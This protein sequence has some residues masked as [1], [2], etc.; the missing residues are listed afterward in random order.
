MESDNSHDATV[1]RAEEGVITHKTSLETQIS[2]FRQPK[3]AHLSFLVAL[4]TLSASVI[5]CAGGPSWNTK[6]YQQWEQKDILQ[7]LNDSP[8]AVRREVEVDWNHSQ[9]GDPND[10]M[11]AARANAGI[12]S[13]GQGEASTVQ[14]RQNTDYPNYPN[15]NGG[16]GVSSG[17]G[18]PPVPVSV[19][20]ETFFT[21]RWNSSRTMQKA[22]LRDG[23]LQGKLTEAMADKY[24]AQPLPDYEIVV[25]GPDMRPF[26]NATEDQLK[27]KG[28]I[29]SRQSKQ[30]VF[31]S[32]ITM[33][34]SPDGKRLIAVLF[35]FPKVAGNNQPLIT[36]KDKGVR[37]ECKIKD[38]SLSADFDLHKMVDEKG[39]DL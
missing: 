33:Q 13:L 38:L 23:V 12:G 5:S 26:V 35:S 39:E 10:S 8:W 28:F 2:R 1:P 37:F 34:R 31:P 4:V 30:K 19:A 27:A 17:A 6:P 7:E 14:Q 32:I 3:Y 21:I 15:Q 9:S 11:A 25:F 24:L 22:V 18:T 29:E 36:K 16:C 20:T